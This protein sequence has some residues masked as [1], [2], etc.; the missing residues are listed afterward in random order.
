MNF[1]V[2]DLH[3][4]TALKLLGKDRRSLG[5]LRK[6]DLNI[7]LEEENLTR[8]SFDYKL[9]CCAERYSY[10]ITAKERDDFRS[11]GNAVFSL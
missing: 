6:N 4:D 7:D 2:F 3:C 5:S 9:T 1:P 10:R 11:V 8:V